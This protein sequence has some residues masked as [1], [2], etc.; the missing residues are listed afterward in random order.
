MGRY[1]RSLRT[2]TLLGLAACSITGLSCRMPASQEGEG[3]RPKLLEGRE[4]EISMSRIGEYPRRVFTSASSVPV[5]VYMDPGLADVRRVR[6]YAVWRR[7]AGTREWEK[8]GTVM[9]QGEPLRIEPGEG[10]HGLRASAVY[11]D[12]SEVL[13]PGKKDEAGS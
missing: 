8:L 1:R 5:R 4:L 11:D 13:V 6:E 9:P 2:I 12:G 10:M 7:P 3:P